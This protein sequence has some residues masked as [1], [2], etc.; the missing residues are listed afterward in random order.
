[1]ATKVKKLQ[2]V[3][4]TNN[5]VF[6]LDDGTREITLVNPYGK[7]ICKLHIRTGDVA[8]YDR[9]KA[10]MKD[11][12]AIV[13]PLSEMDITKDGDAVFEENWARLKKVENDLKQRINE[14]FDM[15][16]ADE[17]FASRSPF[18]SV[19]GHFFVENVL[20]VL[21]QVIASAIED[22]AKMSAERVKKHLEDIEDVN[23]NAGATAD[24][25]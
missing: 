25:A 1:M 19:N 23:A 22:E 21:G 24:N 17:L 13:Q 8:I 12:D 18:S 20:T 3:Q 7:V 11:F 6:T 2:T 10:L 4:Q 5:G 16:E 15:D 14:L 9:Y